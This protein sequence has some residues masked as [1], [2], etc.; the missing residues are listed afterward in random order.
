MSMEVPSEKLAWAVSF[1]GTPTGE[2]KVPVC[3]PMVTD[4]T[5]ASVTVTVASSLMEVSGTLAT[6]PTSPTSTGVTTPL[7]LTSAIAVSLLDQVTSWVTSR[8]VPSLKVPIAASGK[9]TVRGVEN[10]PFLEVT[11]TC[12]KTASV[13]VSEVTV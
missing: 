9:S 4:S 10:V 12:S 2:E 1:K 11:F 13:T 7:L 5:S 6:I 3:E 8:D